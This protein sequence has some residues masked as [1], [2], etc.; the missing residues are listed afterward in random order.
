[1]LSSEEC[2]DALYELVMSKIVKL[3]RFPGDRGIEGNER[4]NEVAKCGFSTLP[5]GTGYYLRSPNT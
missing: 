5:W 4:I 1:M 2:R 3:K